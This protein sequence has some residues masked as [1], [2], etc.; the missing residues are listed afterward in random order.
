MIRATIA[1]AMLAA[2]TTTYRITIDGATLHRRA[3][4]L[5]AH[6][7]VMVEAEETR[8]EAQGD[9]TSHQIAEPLAIDQTVTDHLGRTRWLRDL[10]RGCSPT[11]FSAAAN[12]D[13]ELAAPTAFYEVRRYERHNYT[14][15]A[16]VAL[17]GTLVATLAGAGICAASCKEGTTIETVSDYT[18]GIAATALAGALI[19]AIVDCAG[20]WGEP[21]CRD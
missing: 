3:A 11:D 8:E 1:L 13:C 21:G 5:A 10:L 20:H 16:Q 15:F 14:R 7:T 4:E 6:P 9:S 17:V 12:P 2:C 19:W 18:V